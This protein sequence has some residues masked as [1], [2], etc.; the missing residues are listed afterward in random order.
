MQLM[1]NPEI[2]GVEYQQGTLAGIRSQGISFA[3][4]GTK[5]CLLRERKHSFA[6]RTYGTTRQAWIKQDE[7][8]CA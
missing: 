5:V 4:V 7:Q 2:S 6:D 1:E 3:E 8:S